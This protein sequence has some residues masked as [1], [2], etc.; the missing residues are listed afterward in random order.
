MEQEQF[1]EKKEERN[2]ELIALYY[3]HQ[4]TQIMK[5]RVNTIFDSQ[6]SDK[7]EESLDYEDIR[8]LKKLDNRADL[9]KYYEE[10][11]ARIQEEKELEV[12]A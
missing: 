11:N 2:E 7:E 1:K 4:A 10:N 8:D 3:N 6:E 12:W 9:L 5:D